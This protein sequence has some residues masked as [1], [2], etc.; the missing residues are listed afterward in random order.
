MDQKQEKNNV[1]GHM[2]DGLERINVVLAFAGVS[3]AER[4]LLSDP[5]RSEA[6]LAQK[7]S[8]IVSNAHD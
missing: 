3:A 1:P 5:E 2:S 8:Q 4:K 7:L 6:E